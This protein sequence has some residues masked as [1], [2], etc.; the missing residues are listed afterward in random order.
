MR[1]FLFSLAAMGLCGAAFV[2]AC[3]SDDST[4]S[5]TDGGG[6]DTGVADNYVPPQDSGKKDAGTDA[7]GPC[8]TCSDFLENGP[9]GT[10]CTDNGPPS[11]AQLINDFFFGCMCDVDGGGCTAT[12]GTTCTAFTAPTD[13][14]ITCFSST[15]S[16][17]LAACSADGVDAGPTVDAGDGGDGG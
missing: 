15:C 14:C 5:G 11:S 9:T 1:R 13:D 10:A 8:Q 7:A 2:V 17:Q 12:C 3:S 16:A 6:G 4:A